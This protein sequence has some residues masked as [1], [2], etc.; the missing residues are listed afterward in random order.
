MSGLLP[1][2]KQVSKECCMVMGG[3]LSGDCCSAMKMLSEFEQW[4]R[5][6]VTAELQELE[7]FGL[8]YGSAC[9]LLKLGESTQ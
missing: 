1:E 4:I 9:S 6:G 5:K 3:W 8:W 7:A 2:N